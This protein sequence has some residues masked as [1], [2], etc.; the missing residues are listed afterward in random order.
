MAG[1]DFYRESNLDGSV[2]IQT[3]KGIAGVIKNI[4]EV[5][6]NNGAIVVSEDKINVARA[7]QIVQEATGDKGVYYQIATD[8]EKVWSILKSSVE[9]DSIRVLAILHGKVPKN[10]PENVIHISVGSSL[11]GKIPPHVV[12]EVTSYI[13]S[14]GKLPKKVDDTMYFSFQVLSYE[15]LYSPEYRVFKEQVAKR[16]PRSVAFN[17]LYN[18]P[19]NTSQETKASSVYR[20]LEDVHG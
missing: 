16:V 12:S 7:T 3:P 6:N 20:F 4:V 10:F 1:L 5:L 11:H 2:A 18:V 15:T 14:S 19:E 17:F 9:E 13:N 8:D